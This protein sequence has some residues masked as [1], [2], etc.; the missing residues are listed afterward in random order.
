M[1]ESFREHRIE[2]Q[3]SHPVPE[4]GVGEEEE[5]RRARGEL[6]RGGFR[7]CPN[8]VSFEGLRLAGLKGSKVGLKG[9]AR[10]GERC[11]NHRGAACGS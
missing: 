1:S 4:G 8:E 5:R 2:S 6:R 11:E 9:G 7:K 3:E 10:G